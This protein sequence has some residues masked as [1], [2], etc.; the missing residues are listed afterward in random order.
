MPE[1]IAILEDDSRRPAAM[2]ECVAKLLPSMEVVFF[3][4][5]RAMIQWL[6]DNL[7]R[8][9]ALSLDHDLPS[10]VVDG[11]SV[12]YGTGR[13]V[14]D[15]LTSVLPTCPVIVHSSNQNAAEGMFY[16]LKSAGWPCYRVYPFDG[17]QWIPGAWA[18]Q[19]RSLSRDGWIEGGKR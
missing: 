15:Y 18:D 7:G 19:L 6:C 4:E 11:K 17:E 5:A 10:P 2:R 1:V 12:D 8:V 14:A 9:A 3:D 16:A 13:E